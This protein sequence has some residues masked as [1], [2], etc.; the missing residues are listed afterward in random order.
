M[1]SSCILIIAHGAFS[2]IQPRQHKADQHDGV[3]RFD[4]T[5]LRDWNRPGPLH[6]FKNFTGDNALVETDEAL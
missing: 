2:P 1:Q 5:H 4:E 3:I 6:I